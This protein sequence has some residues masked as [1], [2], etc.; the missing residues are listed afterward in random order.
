MEDYRKILGDN[1][2]S[3][4]AAL[5]ISQE[6]L[7]L[8]VGIDRT[9]ISGIERGRR[10]PSLKVIALIA[11]RLKTTPAQLLKGAND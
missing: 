10:N 11:A 9:Y 7:G 3:A 6:A 8:E 5:D 4:R 1:V 2:R